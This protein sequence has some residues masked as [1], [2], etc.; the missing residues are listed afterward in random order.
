[1]DYKVSKEWN[2]ASDTESEQDPVVLAP[3]SLL[4]AFCLWKALVK[5]Q[6]WSE[7]WELVET[8]E[9]SQRRLNNNVVVAKHSQGPFVLSQGL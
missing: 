4:P 7:K 5:E 2:L 3:L 8:K 9:N 1:M 6:V